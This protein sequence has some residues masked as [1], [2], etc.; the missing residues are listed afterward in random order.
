MAQSVD[1]DAI[2]NGFVCLDL[3]FVRDTEWLNTI[4]GEKEM[5]TTVQ[6]ISN[7]WQI[8]QAE[9]KKFRNYIAL[10]LQGQFIMDSQ[11]QYHFHKNET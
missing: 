7:N 2:Y 10:S 8:A 9:A 4:E 3:S 5:V 1:H 11:V 6:E